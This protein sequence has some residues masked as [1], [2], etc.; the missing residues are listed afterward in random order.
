VVRLGRR[1]IADRM[2]AG[3]M[4]GQA[5]ADS[6]AATAKPRTAAKPALLFAFSVVSGIIDPTSMTSRA[7]AAN[8]SIAASNRW[9][10]MLAIA[11]PPIVASVH[12]PA[13][14]AHKLTMRRGW[15]PAAFMSVD[16]PIDSGKLETKIATSSETRIP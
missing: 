12:A 14:I 10:V 7:P 15:F 4:W 9:A 6:P 16:E 11:Y 5:R 8:S 13:T 3:R 2:I 1:M